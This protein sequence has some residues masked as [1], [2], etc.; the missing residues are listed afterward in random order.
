MKLKKFHQDIM[1]EKIITTK[2]ENILPVELWTKI[3]QFLHETHF[4]SVQDVCVLF[5]NI[6]QRFVEHGFIKSDFYVSWHD[7]LGNF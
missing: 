6:I 7:I 5:W 2:A 4:R 3:L 1:S